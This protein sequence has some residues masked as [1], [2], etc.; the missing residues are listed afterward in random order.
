MALHNYIYIKHKEDS[1]VNKI[2]RDH[3]PRPVCHHP[4]DSLEAKPMAVEYTEDESDEDCTCG[5]SDCSGCTQNRPYEPK[6]IVEYRTE[7]P[8]EAPETRAT[9]MGAT[10]ASAT[11]ESKVALKDGK[12][13]KLR[14]RKRPA[15][16]VST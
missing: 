10:A 4:G 5:G 13:R 8:A 7:R 12:I 1:L 11:P 2:A 15:A 14:K 6:P 9:A 16:P 3:D